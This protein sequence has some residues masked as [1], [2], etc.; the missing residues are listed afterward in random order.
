MNIQRKGSDPN[1]CKFMID[2]GTG[3]G[4]VAGRFHQPEGGVHSQA[5]GSPD[6]GPVFSVS[7]VLKLVSARAA[8]RDKFMNAWVRM[9]SETSQS[10]IAPSLGTSAGHAATARGSSHCQGRRKAGLERVPKC[11]A[12]VLRGKV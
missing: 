3:F 2:H 5:P 10:L 11:G 12:L 6:F 4:T 1:S 7:V 9:V 8:V